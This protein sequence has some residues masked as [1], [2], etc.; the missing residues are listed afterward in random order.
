MSEW[1]RFSHN[2]TDRQTDRQTAYPYHEVFLV[3][4]GSEVFPFIRC[5]WNIM[6]VTQHSSKEHLA[7][8]SVRRSAAVGSEGIIPSFRGIKRDRKSSRNPKLAIN[9]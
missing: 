8:A 1:F 2:L 3:H 7:E 9:Q 5:R 4:V 6:E